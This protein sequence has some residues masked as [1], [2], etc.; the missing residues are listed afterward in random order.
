MF[1]PGSQVGI[2]L[3]AAPTDMR[4]SFTSLAAMAPVNV[5]DKSVADFSFLAGMLLNKF[6]CHLPLYRQHQRLEHNDIKVAR[7]G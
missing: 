4:R 6:L 5:L 1:L 2:W 3:H 7:T